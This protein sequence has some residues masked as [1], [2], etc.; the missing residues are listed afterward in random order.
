M[1]CQ[2]RCRRESEEDIK[3]R[4]EREKKEEEREEKERIPR[5]IVRSFMT[6]SI[7][8]YMG[9]AAAVVALVMFCVN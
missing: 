5:L 1:A 4:E 2:C 7:G 6:L 9:I 3:K 8:Y